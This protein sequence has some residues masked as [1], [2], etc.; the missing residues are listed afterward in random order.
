MKDETLLP[1]EFEAFAKREG[2]ITESYGLRSVNSAIDVARKAW[3][4]ALQSGNSGQPVTVPAGYVLVPVEPT[5]DMLRA[6]QAVVGFW[7]NTL[8]CYA[9]M[10]SAA[11]KAPD[12]WIPV[13]EG[14]RLMGNT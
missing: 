3:N 12:G 4:A 2:L 10:L 13:S 7:L 9:A 11:P 6:G 14:C 1:D 5:K 8:H